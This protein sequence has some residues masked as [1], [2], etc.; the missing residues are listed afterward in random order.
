MEIMEKNTRLFVVLTCGVVF[1]FMG[2]FFL[3]LFGH[4]SQSFHIL[5]KAFIL[6]A[7]SASLFY[8]FD[9]TLSLLG[10]TCTHILRFPLC[11]KIVILPVLNLFSHMMPL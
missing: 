2:V 10:F 7:C 4:C 3:E 11:L 5:A 6:S 8:F 1:S 9:I